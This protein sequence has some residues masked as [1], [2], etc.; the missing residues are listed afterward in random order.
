MQPWKRRA[1]SMSTVWP[2]Q[3]KKGRGEEKEHSPTAPPAEQRGPMEAELAAAQ[4]HTG[5]LPGALP[6][7]APPTAAGQSGRQTSEAFKQLLQSNPRLV[8]SRHLPGASSPQPNT[9]LFFRRQNMKCSSFI[10]LHR[11]EGCVCVCVGGCVVSTHERL[12]LAQA[13]LLSVGS[14][15]S[16]LLLFFLM[17]LTDCRNGSFAAGQNERKTKPFLRQAIR[18]KAG[19]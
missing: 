15:C 6:A 4:R 1:T 2:S 13:A 3:E 12:Q 16:D 11:R 14:L 5:R 7:L 9:P 8:R 18:M 19:I 17:T 10:F